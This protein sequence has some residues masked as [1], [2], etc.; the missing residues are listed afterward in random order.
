MRKK[1]VAGRA[2]SSSRIDLR[3][4]QPLAVGVDPAVVAVR[5]GVEHPVGVEQQRL[6]LARDRHL[7]QLRSRRPPRIAARAQRQHA[8]QRA[9]EALLRHRLQQV[10]DGVD[11]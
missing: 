9:R 4:Q 8:L 2:S 11:A 3:R 5:L 10:V 7:L 1:I 6:A